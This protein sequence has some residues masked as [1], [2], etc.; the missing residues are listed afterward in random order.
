VSKPIPKE[1]PIR[2]IK[3]LAKKYSIE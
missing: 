3:K 2:E 1:H